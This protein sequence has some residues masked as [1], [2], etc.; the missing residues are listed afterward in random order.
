MS[1]WGCAVCTAAY[2]VGLP[3]CPQCGSTER[4]GETAVPKITRAG[5]SYEPGRGHTGAAGELPA[6]GADPA[7]PVTPDVPVQAAGPQP[8]V[9]PAAGGPPAPDAAPAPEPAEPKRAPRKAS[10][11]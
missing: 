3:R 8:A 1:V 7:G 6:G 5:V 11:G 2:A 4:E 9:A 10:D